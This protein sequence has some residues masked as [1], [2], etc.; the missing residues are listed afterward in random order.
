MKNKIVVFILTFAVMVLATPFVFD[1]LMNSKF[2]QMLN[3]LKKEGYVIKE[4]ENKSS[5][6]TTDRVFEVVI[7]GKKIDESGYIKDVI[8][9]VEAKFKNLPVT[10][11]RF[12]GKLLKIESFNKNFEE[13]I[14]KIIK[15]KIKFIVITP[16]FK[17]YKYKIEDS[18]LNVGINEISFK[19]IDGIYSYPS[20]NTLNISSLLFKDIRGIS[21]EVKLFK[22]IYQKENNVIKT[23]TKFN[24]YAALKQNRISI[25]NITSNS[26]TY[27]GD[28][29]K[30]VSDL[31]FDTMNI[32]NNVMIKD[33]NLKFIADKIDAKTLKELQNVTDS[34]QQEILIQKLLSRGLELNANLKIKDIEAFK[35]KLGFLDVD[36]KLEIKPDDRLFDKLKNKDLSDIVF[37]V[38]LKTTPQMS[39]VIMNLIPQSSFVFALAKKEK[40]M[41]EVVLKLKNGEIYINGEK[42]KSN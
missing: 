34:Q 1:K 33:F 19:G 20:K 7:P 32:L 27:L 39:L 35:Q 21:F 10:D 26:V 17:V 6:L 9:K 31:H 2:N 4:I 5:Y 37:F 14:N 12:F 23:N 29:I 22:N 36:A 38:N 11:V 30:S 16:N 15:D 40:N 3:N 28:L 42:I 18:K 41:I 13:E 8:L 25:L 24:F